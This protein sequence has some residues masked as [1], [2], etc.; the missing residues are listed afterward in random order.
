VDI[1]IATTSSGRRDTDNDDIVMM[2]LITVDVGVGRNCL[3]SE[4]V[5]M[6]ARSKRIYMM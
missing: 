2:Y 6:M 3:F 5:I 1:N 4:Q